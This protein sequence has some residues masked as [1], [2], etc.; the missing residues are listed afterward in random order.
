M[1]PAL[2]SAAEREG[3]LQKRSIPKQIEFWAELGKS[4][5][6]VIEHADVFAVLQG[7]K[8]INVEPAASVTAAS[9]DVFSALEKSRKNGELTNAVTTA[10][11]YYEASTERPGLLDRVNTVTGKRCSGQFRDGKFK[12]LE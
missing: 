12:V 2:I 11:V 4:V 3:K 5:E 10:A 1:N 8:K 7:L 9:D 6:R